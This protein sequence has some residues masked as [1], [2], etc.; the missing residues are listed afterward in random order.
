MPRC[1]ACGWPCAARDAVLCDSCHALA[2]ATTARCSCCALP[3]M[4]AAPATTR[5]GQCLAHPPAFDA[6][7]TA[8]NYQ[9]LLRDTLHRFKFHAQPGLARWFARELASP[10]QALSRDTWLMPVPLSRQRLKERGYNQSLVIARQLSRLTG[11]TL[12]P[13]LVLRVRDTPQQSSLKFKERR[14]NIKGAFACPTRLDGMRIAVVDD[15]MT[16]GATLEEIAFTLKKAG[17]AYVT[18]VVMFRATRDAS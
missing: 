13:G 3:L 18:N 2:F 5:C 4:T 6:T 8:A 11:L 1:M 17:A 10:C 16:S 9:G 15:V 7:L 14:S 12:R